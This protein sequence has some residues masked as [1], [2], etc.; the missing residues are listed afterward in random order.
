MFPSFY[1]KPNLLQ[2]GL[3]P[4]MS[5]GEVALYEYLI[6]MCDKRSSRQFKVD[7][8]D[9]FKRTGISERTLIT[10]RKKLLKKG[11]ILY[12]LHVYE[13]CDPETL[14]P[15]PG[16]PK[17]IPPRKKSSSLQPP[18]P[19]APVVAVEIKPVM[20]AEGVD[21]CDTDFHYGWNLITQAAAQ[22]APQSTEKTYDFLAAFAAN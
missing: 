1:A 20:R 18:Q 14:K 6:E 13:V 4:K 15:F 7:H 9:V 22:P 2:L 21:L 16:D 10:A 3:L 5:L 19:P 11:L 12:R 17:M 8:E